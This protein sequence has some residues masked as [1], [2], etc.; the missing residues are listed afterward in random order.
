MPSPMKRYTADPDNKGRGPGIYY[1]RSWSK[2]NN[3]QKIYAHHSKYSRKRDEKIKARGWRHNDKVSQYG[4][5]N[6]PLG[7]TFDGYQLG[8]KIKKDKKSKAYTLKGK[9]Y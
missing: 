7:H 5:P 9:W 6:F 3:T 4:T 2:A 1:L 8:N